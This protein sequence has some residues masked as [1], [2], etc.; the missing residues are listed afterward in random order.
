LTL[1]DSN[2]LSTLSSISTGL[3]KGK[4]QKKRALLSLLGPLEPHFLPL[5]CLATSLGYKGD[6]RRAISDLRGD[7]SEEVKET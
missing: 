1:S 3:P 2:L 5:G 4:K 7:A 6:V